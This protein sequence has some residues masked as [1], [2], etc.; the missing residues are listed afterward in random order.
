MAYDIYNVCQCLTCL[1]TWHLLR[2]HRY[3]GVLIRNIVI[4]FLVQIQLLQYGEETF[5]VKFQ[6]PGEEALVSEES[7]DV[8]DVTVP[9]EVAETALGEAFSFKEQFHHPQ[10]LISNIC[11]AML[12]PKLFL[13]L[14]LILCQ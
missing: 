2:I 8:E 13:P 12:N 7:D 4:W 5:R 10:Y 9:F 6:E 3:E 1:Q 14:G 11:S